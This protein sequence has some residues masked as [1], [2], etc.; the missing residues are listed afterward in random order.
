MEDVHTTRG[1][2]RKKCVVVTRELT[3]KHL[4]R[5]DHKEY[6]CASLPMFTLRNNVAV[7][8]SVLHSHWLLPLE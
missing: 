6:S 3:L 5:L 2:V 4:L 1:D 8:I 7:H